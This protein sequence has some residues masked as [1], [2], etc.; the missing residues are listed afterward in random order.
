MRSSA[1]DLGVDADARLAQP[2]E[3]GEEAGPT[4]GPLRGQ[5]RLERVVVGIHAQAQDVQL[6]ARDL[7][8]QALA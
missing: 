7:E 4:G 2:I 8:A 1:G 6:A 5:C 3:R